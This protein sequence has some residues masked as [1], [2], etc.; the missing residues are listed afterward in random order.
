MAESFSTFAAAIGLAD[1]LFRMCGSLYRSLVELGKISEQVQ[2]LT[3]SMMVWTKI[4]QDVK[5]LVQQYQA[6]PIMTADSFSVRGLCDASQSCE[7]ACSTV[8]ML[9]AEYTAARDRSHFKLAQDLKWMLD[10]RR[11]QSAQKRLDQARQF[12]IIA[13]NTIGRW[14]ACNIKILGEANEGIVKML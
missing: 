5:D 10:A 7:L 13:L 12:I 14:D 11:L 6:S 3:D 8:N 2:N 9:V 4:N 1:V